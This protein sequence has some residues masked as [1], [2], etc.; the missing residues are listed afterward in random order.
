MNL[1][2]REGWEWARRNSIDF[3]PRGLYGA[4]GLLE[5]SKAAWIS[6]APGRLTIPQL[7]ISPHR[8]RIVYA[9]RLKPKRK[10]SSPG[11]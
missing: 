4:L 1:I 3:D 2:S 8:L 11:E 9:P 7:L 10:I 6:R 5:Y